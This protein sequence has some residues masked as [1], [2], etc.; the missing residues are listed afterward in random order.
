MGVTQ[1]GSK[2]N[3]WVEIDPDFVDILR[4]KSIGLPSQYLVDQFR[5]P[6]EN[7]SPK[8]NPFRA[9]MRE[10]ITTAL[11]VIENAEAGKIPCNCNTLETCRLSD[12]GGW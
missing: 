10:R 6:G 11:R 5:R 3:P 2:T 7:E 8:S 1:V 4:D 12:R 9:W